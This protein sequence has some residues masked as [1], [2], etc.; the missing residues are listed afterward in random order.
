MLAIDR[1]FRNRS[2]VLLE[3]EAGMGKTATAGQFAEWYTL[4]EGFNGPVLFTSFANHKTLAAVLDQLAVVFQE[5]L[6]KAD[7]SW[8]TLPPEERLEVAL[9]VLN[10]ISVLWVWD[11][12]EQ[13]AGFPQGQSSSWTVEEQEELANF[14]RLAR[15]AQAKFLLLSRPVKSHWL[16]DLHATVEL[17]PL[18]IRER[19]QLARSL[20]ERDGYTLGDVTTGNR[21]SSFP[22]EIPWLF[23][24]W[25]SKRCARVSKAAPK[26]VTLSSN[27][28]RGLLRSA[29]TAPWVSRRISPRRSTT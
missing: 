3:A 27:S 16:G 25:P 11:N 28:S 19:L 8:I 10:Q 29:G 23:K 6:K 2:V 21:F 7:Y 4:T 24:A 20:A 15:E 12:V 1:T 14:L 22:R 18:P 13:V 17:P 9:H 26:F 5:A